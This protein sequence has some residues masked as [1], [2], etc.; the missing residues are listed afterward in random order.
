MLM[1]RC[2]L[3]NPSS[4]DRFLRTR[5]PSSKVTGRPPVS[6]NFVIRALAMVDFP[7]PERPVRSEEHTSELQSLRHIVCRLLLEKKNTI[8]TLH[9]CLDSL[10][11][12]YQPFQKSRMPK[13]D[14]IVHVRLICSNILGRT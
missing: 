11:V 5:S 7:E 6:R 2:S 12:C 3:E 9:M 13:T 1:S 14:Q 8:Q 10:R 4:E